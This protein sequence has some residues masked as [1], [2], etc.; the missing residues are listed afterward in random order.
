MKPK[1]MYPTPTPATAPAPA[2]SSFPAPAPVRWGTGGREEEGGRRRH[3]RHQDQCEQQ[4]I[5]TR[6]I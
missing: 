3:S 1:G 6:E 2:P 5:V 4:M